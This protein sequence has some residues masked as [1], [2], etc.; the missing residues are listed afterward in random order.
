MQAG[1]AA[2]TPE[3]DAVLRGAPGSGGGLAGVRRGVD[4]IPRL[5]ELVLASGARH[6]CRGCGAHGD[7]R[8][9]LGHV[10]DDVLERAPGIGDA[11][12]AAGLVAVEMDKRREAGRRAGLIA[13]AGGSFREVKQRGRQAAAGGRG[14]LSAFRCMHCGETFRTHPAAM[15]HHVRQHRDGD[16]LRLY[17]VRGT[18]ALR[19]E[20]HA[21]TA[22]GAFF[23]GAD[24]E[25]EKILFP[26]NAVYTGEGREKIR[27]RKCETW[28]VEYKKGNIRS[29]TLA[30]SKWR[31]HESAC[32]K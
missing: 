5:I 16:A 10:V 26:E 6:F 11:G 9:L 28:E 29:A 3:V 1:E 8:G 22:G 13:A 30:V 14:G 4:G 25:L 15:V 18:G 23:G 2:H 27:C 31:R 12:R 17:K 32:S 7:R 19:P 21:A 20:G 24:A